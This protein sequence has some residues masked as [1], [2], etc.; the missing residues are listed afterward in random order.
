M[1]CPNRDYD[2]TES[3]EPEDIA[4]EMYALHVRECSWNTLPL[5]RRLEWIAMAR[6]A[7]EAV[8]QAAYSA[9]YDGGYWDAVEKEQG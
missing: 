3:V 9:G 6:V 8:A 5:E 2:Y 4:R 7:C 1:A